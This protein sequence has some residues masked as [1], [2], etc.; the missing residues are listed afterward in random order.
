MAADPMLIATARQDLCRFLSA[1]YYEP[2]IDFTDAHLF[3]SIKAVSAILH[4]DL[5]A[6]ADRVGK[7]FA[8]E[9]LQALLVDHTRLFVGPARPLAMPYGSAWLAG[10]SNPALEH[11]FPVQKVYQE[12][13]FDLDEEFRDLPDHIAVELEFLYVLHFTQNQALLGDSDKDALVT[14]E[15]RQRFLRE[16]LGKWVGPF[17]TAV[18]A[19]A[20]TVFYRELAEL[21]ERFIYTEAERKS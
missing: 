17:A 9:S 13:G 7:A 3:E 2:S 6:C 12:G 10:G 14:E 4:P 11:T 21:T 20:E 19:H 5:A 8:G 1:C 16:H 15:L 18:R